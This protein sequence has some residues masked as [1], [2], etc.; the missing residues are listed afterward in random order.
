MATLPALGALEMS[1][2]LGARLWVLGYSGKSQRIR[3][4]A[5]AT[6]ASPE[7]LVHCAMNVMLYEY[8]TQTLI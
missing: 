8:S 3:R 2:A 5:S 7:L 4:P 6:S 1:G